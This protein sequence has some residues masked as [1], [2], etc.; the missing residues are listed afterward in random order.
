MLDLLTDPAAWLSLAT[1]TLMEV[2]L[3]IDNIIFISILAGKLPAAEQGRARWI[4]LIGACVMRLGLLSLVSFIA[5]LT[6]PLVTLAGHEVSGRDLILLGGGLFLLYKATMEIHHKLEGADE[7]T[8]GRRAGTTMTAGIVQIML[9][10]IVFSLDS[11]ITA[12]GMTDHLAIMMAAVILSLGV[13]LALGKPIGDFVMRHP[14]VKILAL[15]FLLLIGVTL[16]AEGFGQHLSKGYIYGA[17]A[18]SIFVETLNLTYRRRSERAPVRLR[19]TAVGVPTD[20]EPL[21]PPGA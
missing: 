18:F 12:I 7:A 8:D 9:L 20:H 13:M 1:L 4:G 2:V 3:G 6:R 19:Q 14:S 11:V 21:P 15:S 16:I 5:K 17:M 10:D